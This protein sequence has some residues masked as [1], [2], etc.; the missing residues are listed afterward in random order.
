MAK[1]KEAKVKLREVKAGAV[2]AKKSITP[3]LKAFVENPDNKELAVAYRGAVSSHI[4]MVR[5]MTAL[6][7]RVERLAAA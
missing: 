3:A 1:L 2:A 6:Q 5:S 7:H 4:K